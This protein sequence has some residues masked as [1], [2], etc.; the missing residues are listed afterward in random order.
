MFWTLGALKKEYKL[1]MSNLRLT[2]TQ[3]LITQDAKH[4]P[5][6]QT[7]PGEL[8]KNEPSQV[9]PRSADFK[10]SRGGSYAH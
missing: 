1:G 8:V 10:R 4:G 3:N 5:E 9:S 6:A 2:R 7:S